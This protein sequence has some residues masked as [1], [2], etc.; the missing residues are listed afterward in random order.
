VSGAQRHDQGYGIIGSSVG[1]NQE[2]RFHAA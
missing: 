1:I 2:K